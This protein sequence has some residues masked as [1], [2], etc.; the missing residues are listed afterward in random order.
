MCYDL[1][2]IPSN[3]VS[4]DPQIVKCHSNRSSSTGEA[5]MT[6]LGFCS[7]SLTSRIIRRIAGLEDD[8]MTH[9]PDTDAPL[10]RTHSECQ[11]M[12]KRFESIRDG[13]LVWVR[14]ILIVDS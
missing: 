5:I 4:F 1:R 2:L 14:E 10:E 7:Q 12:Q 3:S 9:T 6:S 11:E 8:M 13:G